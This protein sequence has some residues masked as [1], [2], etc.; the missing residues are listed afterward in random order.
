[1]NPPTG[2]L[3]EENLLG[4]ATKDKLVL[5]AEQFAW[6]EL[7]DEARAVDDEDGFAHAFNMT[8][9]HFFE[10]DYD[11]DWMKE[12]SSDASSLDNLSL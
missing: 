11:I 10:V 1:M 5:E 6:H 12:I 9:W 2:S 8:S 7:V 3:T 4:P